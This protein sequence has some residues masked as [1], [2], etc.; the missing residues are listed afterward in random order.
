MRGQKILGPTRDENPCYYCKEP[1]RHT[2][3]HD[4]CKKHATWKAEIERVKANR[5]EYER[6]LG[7]R[8]KR[9]GGKL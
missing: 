6:K 5:R 8:L 7:I 9:N 1:V 3:C 4:T 2:A